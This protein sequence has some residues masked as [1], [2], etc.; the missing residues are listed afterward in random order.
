MGQGLSTGNTSDRTGLP[1]LGTLACYGVTAS[2]K[3]SE[4][5]QIPKGRLNSH[6]SQGPHSPCIWF[7]LLGSSDEG[8]QV[9]LIAEAGCLH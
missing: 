4:L 6:I 7:F 3:R 5:L 8:G 1:D 9:L 2:S